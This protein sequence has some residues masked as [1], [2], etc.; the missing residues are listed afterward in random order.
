M[1]ANVFSEDEKNE[2]LS[3]AAA[4]PIQLN[5]TYME[6]YWLGLHRQKG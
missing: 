3:S 4:L 6:F 5:E 1:S 2:D